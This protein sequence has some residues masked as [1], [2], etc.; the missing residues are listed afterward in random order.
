LA[1][2]E[3]SESCTQSVEPLRLENSP[4]QDRYLHTGQDKQNKHTQTSVT[5]MGL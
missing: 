2:F 4:S 1:A 3:V 5:R